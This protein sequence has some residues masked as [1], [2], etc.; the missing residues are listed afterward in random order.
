MHQ[1]FDSFSQ[2]QDRSA[3]RMDSGPVRLEVFGVGSANG[4]DRLGWMVL[5]E[6][7][8]KGAGGLVLHR[9]HTPLDLLNY[10]LAGVSQGT[11]PSATD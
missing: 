5:E 1:L 4:A 2:G 11:F 7:D 6:L 9:L 3:V 8:R 10:A